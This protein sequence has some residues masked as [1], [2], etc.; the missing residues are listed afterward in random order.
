[1]RANRPRVGVCVIRVETQ[2]DRL[3]ITIRTNPDIERQ[4]CEKV[5]IVPD[6]SALIEIIRSFLAKF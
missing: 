1:V 6:E 2:G 5:Q 4:S 3:L